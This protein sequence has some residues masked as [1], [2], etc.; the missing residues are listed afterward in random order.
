MSYDLQSYNKMQTKQEY[1]L[2]L[3]FRK[4]KSKH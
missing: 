1:L 4:S 2:F 3:F